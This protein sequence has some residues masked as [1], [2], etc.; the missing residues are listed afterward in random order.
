M[1]NRRGREGWSRLFSGEKQEEHLALVSGVLWGFEHPIDNTPGTWKV[2]SNNLRATDRGY[3][4][5][6][7]CPKCEVR[8]IPIP[9]TRVN[10]GKRKGLGRK[11]QPLLQLRQCEM[12][13]I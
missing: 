13:A 1:G 6:E 11:T 9:R 3:A 8:R 12:P 7:E 5:Y 10:K 2:V 4:N